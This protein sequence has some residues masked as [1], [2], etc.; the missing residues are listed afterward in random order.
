MNTKEM[1]SKPTLKRFLTHA[2]F[3]VL[4]IP[5]IWALSHLFRPVFNL[6]LPVSFMNLEQGKVVYDKSFK[7]Q[8]VYIGGQRFRFPKNDNFKYQGGFF[9]SKQENEHMSIRL[10]WPDISLNGN[11]RSLYHKSS[12][13]HYFDTRFY[14]QVQGEKKAINF[15]SETFWQ[16]HPE[17]NKSDYIS[18]DNHKDGLRVFIHKKHPEKRCSYA[19]DKL[20]YVEFCGGYIFSCKPTIWVSTYGWPDIKDIYGNPPKWQEVHQGIVAVLNRYHQEKHH[21]PH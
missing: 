8:I 20:N 12:L 2:Y 15:N 19:L 14:V 5:L 4:S 10:F 6:I 21:A 9:K 3:I 11:V 13:D 18:Q 1:L 16:R 17:L 7:Y